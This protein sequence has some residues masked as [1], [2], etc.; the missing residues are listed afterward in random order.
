MIGGFS[1]PT[2]GRVSTYVRW[3]IIDNYK[4]LLDLQSC[5]L[6]LELKFTPNIYEGTHVSAY[7]YL[8][9]YTGCL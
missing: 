9:L 3:I 1:P 5:P 6:E 8:Y 4:E 7:V 2:A